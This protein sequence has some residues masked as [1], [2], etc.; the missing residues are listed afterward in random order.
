MIWLKVKRVTISPSLMALVI[1]SN[2]S[3]VANTWQ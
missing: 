2:H 1:I 3:N